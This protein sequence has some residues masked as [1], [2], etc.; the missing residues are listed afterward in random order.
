MAYRLPSSVTIEFGPIRSTKTRNSSAVTLFVVRE[1]RGVL[2]SF[3]T[4]RPL[5]KC[6]VLVSSTPQ[7]LGCFVRKLRICISIRGVN[8]IDLD[9]QTLLF[10]IWGKSC[11]LLPIRVLRRRG[12]VSL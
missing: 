1:A 8:Q 4:A 6:M 3:E 2:K 5:H 9:L 12:V 7:S 10:P 11:L